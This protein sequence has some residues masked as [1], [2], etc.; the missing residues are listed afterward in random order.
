MCFTVI[1]DDVPDYDYDAILDN[2]LV[3]PHSLPSDILVV[4]FK[5]ISSI[6]CNW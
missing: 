1:D 3:H 6:A 4:I 5:C 2:I